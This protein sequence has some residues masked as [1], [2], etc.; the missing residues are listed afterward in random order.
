MVAFKNTAPVVWILVAIA[1]LVSGIILL[2]DVKLAWEII[3]AIVSGSIFVVGI[4]YLLSIF[5]KKG[6]SKFKELGI[7]LLC[8][9]G[10][11][12]IYVFPQFIKGTFA[13]AVGALGI[14]M[15]FFVLLS[16]LK[17][18]K[19]G[20]SWVGTLLIALIYIGLGIDMA[21]FATQGRLFGIIFG[22]YLIL[23]SLNIFSDA[24]A[25]LMKNNDGAQKM[26]KHIRVSLPVVI[27]AFLP[28]RLLNKVNKLVAEEPDALLLLSDKNKEQEIDMEIFIHTKAGLLPGIGH[29]DVSMGEVVYSYGNYD[30][31]TWKMGGFFADGVMV[32]MGKASHIK[33]SLDVEKKILMG[34]GLSLPQDQKKGARDKLNEIILD[35]VPWEPLAEQAEK[36]QIDGKPED[37]DDVSSQLYN[38]A[39][40]RFYKFKFGDPFKTYYAMGTNCVKLV[41]TIVG[42]TGIDLMK[43]NGIITPG[44]Y[45]DYLD[46]LYERGDSIVVSRTLYQDIEKNIKKDALPGF[47]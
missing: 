44:A 46:R 8:L 45:L 5:L 2:F 40:A 1:V 42:K 27:A 9:F 43:I 34:Y 4:M 14:I 28:I 12:A 29:V 17:L 3:V 36:G 23:F 39:G 6:E 32:E 22:F 41:D 19:D 20:A 21:F 47:G 25:S 33:Q 7:G 13:F 26:K 18:K 11:V 16:S 30:T 10:G 15:G 38:D 37:Y 24:L 35:L 31:A